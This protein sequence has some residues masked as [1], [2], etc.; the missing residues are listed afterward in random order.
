M[1]A[2]CEPQ[3]S[4]RKS[5]RA[6]RVGAC[7]ALLLLVLLALNGFMLFLEDAQLRSYI[8]G[9]LNSL[10]SSLPTLLEY[11][12]ESLEYL[13]AF[14]DSGFAFRFT[15]DDSSGIRLSAPLQRGI[16]AIRREGNA[17]EI[18]E[19]DHATL[20]RL[21]DLA[22]ASDDP[23]L[24]PIGSGSLLRL[25]D[26][27]MEGDELLEFILQGADPQTRSPVYQEQRAV[28]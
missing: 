14:E 5:R 13:L 20:A 22:E 8:D 19:S 17:V 6:K 9:H 2:E 21:A 1:N 16:R 12:S 27:R 18:T 7:V 3:S 11:N 23:V 28:D 26:G 10:G 24:F 15:L 25:A 4:S